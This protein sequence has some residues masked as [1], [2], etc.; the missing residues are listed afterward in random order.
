MDNNGNMSNS[1]TKKKRTKRNGI[2][3]AIRVIL[4]VICLGACVF[5]GY[6]IVLSIISSKKADDIYGDIGSDIDSIMKDTETDSEVVI[7]TRGDEPPTEPID[8]DEDVSSA[9]TDNSSEPTDV[10]DS[11]TDPGTDKEPIDPDTD[12]GVETENKE[13]TIEIPTAPPDTSDNNEPQVPTY[14]QLFT[15]M[16]TYILS[17]QK[18]NPDVVG[19]IY[20]PMAVGKEEKLISLPVVLTDDNEYYLNHDIY[21]DILREGTIFLDKS[22]DPDIGK[23]KNM[24][25]YGH[26]MFG[27]QMFHNLKYFTDKSVFMSTYIYFF[28]TEA[29]YVYEPFAVYTAKST[30]GYGKMDF[31]DDTEYTDFL[32]DAQSNSIWKKHM[33]FYGSD[34]IITLSTCYGVTGTG[35]RMAIHGVLVK[36]QQ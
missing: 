30:D 16:R 35:E 26:N 15:A 25:V 22:T 7:W 12:T 1:G 36:I 8:T 13:T 20:I 32:Y 3:T 31:Y 11:V 24:V 10:S 34:R 4:V 5:S 27:E 2:I 28:T 21:G 19:I 33:S 6:K 18:I 9:L 23:N 14:S 17:L 29:I